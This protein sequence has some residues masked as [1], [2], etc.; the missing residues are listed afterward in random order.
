MRLAPELKCLGTIRW[1]A[2]CTL[3]F[4][5]RVPS[6]L[7]RFRYL[8]EWLREVAGIAR[9]PLE[10]LDYCVRDECGEKFGRPHYH[11]LIG[12]VP[13]GRMHLTFLRRAGHAW[14][15]GFTDM[16]LWCEGLNALAYIGADGG[17]LY[18]GKKFLHA[19]QLILS[20]S[21]R[22][23]GRTGDSVG[24]GHVQQ[25]EKTGVVNGTSDN[26]GTDQPGI[27]GPKSAIVRHGSGYSILAANASDQGVTLHFA[28]QPSLA[29]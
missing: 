22:N 2:F 8:Q 27:S 23:M 1:Q 24:G 25:S 13:L 3:T 10:A 18:E 20:E 14:K 21:L 9:V 28:V 7:R 12:R 29:F 17:N 5:G 15:L 6:P 11:A 4:A 19:T 16:R 26:A